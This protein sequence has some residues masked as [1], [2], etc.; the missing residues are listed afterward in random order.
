[1]TAAGA[2]TATAVLQAWS[3]PLSTVLPLLLLSACYLRGWLHYHRT[4]PSR[5]SVE[6]LFAFHAGLLALFVALHSP[7]EAFDSLLL[8]A[9]MC[10]HLLL[11][12]VAP[13]LLLWSNPALPLLRGLPRW[14]VKHG[15]GPLLTWSALRRFLAFLVLPPVSWLAF[16]LATIIWHVP[17]SYEFALRSPIWHAAEHACFF[18]TSILFWWPVIQPWP[19]HPRC[20]EWSMIPYLLL[21]DV[22]NTALSAFLIFSDRLLYPSYA[23]ARL[24]GVS[25]R[26]DQAIAGAIMWV[27]GSLI[28]LVPAVKIAVQLLSPPGQT[29]R[30]TRI[31]LSPKAPR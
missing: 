31:S 1:M 29:V 18:W 15:L 10:Q 13:P 14:F 23:A 5:F 25:P 20:P 30:Y 27:P 24:L 3:F 12:M 8:Q 28:Y 7:L 9:H 16:A 19:S 22:I 17:A 2:G 11:M 4:L 26:E 21:A 6:R